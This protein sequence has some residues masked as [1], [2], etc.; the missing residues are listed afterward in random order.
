MTWRGFLVGSE[1]VACVAL[2]AFNNSM[3]RNASGNLI[4]PRGWDLQLEKGI[5]FA[6]FQHYPNQVCPK[7]LEGD[8]V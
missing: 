1:S 7:D 4:N 8:L 5:T 2:L 3:I 6:L